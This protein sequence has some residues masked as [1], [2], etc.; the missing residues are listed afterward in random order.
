MATAFTTILKR[1]LTLSLREM[2]ELLNPLVF[3]IMVVTLFPLAVSPAPQQLRELAAGVVWVA[4]LLAVLLSM[5]KLLRRDYEDGSL[6]QLVLAPQ[7]LYL[8]M[9]A[10]LLAHWLLVGLPLV[11]LSPLIG[12]MFS[13][14]QQFLGLLSL[15]LLLGTPVMVVIGGIGAALTM[16]TRQGGVLVALLVLPLYVPVLIFGSGVMLEVMQGFAVQAHLALLLAL[17][18]F[19]ISLGPVAIAVTV[20]LMISE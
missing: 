2:G 5:D 19:A 3:F 20:R 4:A 15:T 14:P 12:M 8:M 7:S 16:T 6:E 9:L 10:K 13:V 11:V 17:A 18:L 1:D